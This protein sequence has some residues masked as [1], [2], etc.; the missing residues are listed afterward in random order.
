[1]LRE[2]FPGPMGITA[3]RLEKDIG[4]PL[5]RLAAI[6]SGKRSATADTGLRLDRYFGL[7][8]GSALKLNANCVRRSVRSERAQLEQADHVT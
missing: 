6:L 3:Y 1:M 4:V 7:S 5:T 8:G 2:E